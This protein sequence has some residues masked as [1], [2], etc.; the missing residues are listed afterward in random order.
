[1]SGGI[2]YNF[3]SFNYTRTLDKCI[4]LARKK[5][6]LGKRSHRGSS[7]DNSFGSVLHVHGFTDRDM[8]LGVND[9]SQIENLKDYQKNLLVK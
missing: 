2:T 6:L 7:F 1:M 8:V 5:S 3:I 4:D 9:E